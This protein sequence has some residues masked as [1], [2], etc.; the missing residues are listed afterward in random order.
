MSTA[1]YVLLSFIEWPGPAPR[2]AAARLLDFVARTR[3]EPGCLAFE[4][5]EDAARPGRFMVYEVF[6]DDAAFDAHRGQPALA[7]L[8][9]WLAAQGAGVT[10]LRHRMLSAQ[11]PQP[12]APA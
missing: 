3:A 1:P 9:A 8:K 11:E 5:H 2:G 6:R 7:P 10:N 4:L 12:A